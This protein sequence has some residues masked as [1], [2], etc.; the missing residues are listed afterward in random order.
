M[1]DVEDKLWL[2]RLQKVNAD[3]TCDTG[4]FLVVLCRGS[5]AGTLMADPLEYGN[6]PLFIDESALSAPKSIATCGRYLAILSCIRYNGMKTS[7]ETFEPAPYTSYA[8]ALARLNVLRN[9]PSW[10]HC[11]KLTNR[12]TEVEQVLKHERMRKLYLSK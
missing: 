9:E 4:I 1:T 5:E 11:M 2:A 3:L 12:E 6:I 10:T 7:Y 8:T